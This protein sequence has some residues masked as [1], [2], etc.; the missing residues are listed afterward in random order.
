MIRIGE[1]EIQLRN[2]RMEAKTLDNMFRRRV[3]LGANCPPFVSAAILREVKEVYSLD[4]EEVNEPGLGQIRL[5]VTAAQEPPGKI[6]QECQKV[7][8]RLSLDAK[9]DQEIRFRQGTTGLRRARILRM[10][11]EAQEQG[12]LLTYEDLAYRLLNCGVRTIVRDAEALRREGLDVP[13]RGQQQDMG[14]R[15]SHRAKAVELYLQG[16]ESKEI[17]KRLYHAL[18]SIENYVTTFGR[19]VLLMN[20]GYTDDEMAFLLR[21]S[22]ALVAVYRKLHQQY[23]Q[24][25]SARRRIEEILQRLDPKAAEGSLKKGAL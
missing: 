21:R 15:Q 17:A 7:M 24:K 18:S 11:T 4:G 16:Y 25:A 2:G 1:I 3:E 14:P 12:G 10:S 8:V 23:V 13:T 9:E 6:L 20:K 5:L 22:S 19:I